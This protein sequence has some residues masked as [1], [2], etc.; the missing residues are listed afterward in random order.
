LFAKAPAG[1]LGGRAFCISIKIRLAF[2]IDM[3][4]KSGTK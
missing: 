2:S 4:Q 1:R 3:P